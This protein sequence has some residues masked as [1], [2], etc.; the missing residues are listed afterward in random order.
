MS[1]CFK[2][3]QGLNER[4]IFVFTWV[5]NVNLININLLSF[6]ILNNDERFDL[7]KL[8]YGLEWNDIRL[9]IVKLKL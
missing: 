1:L 9:F 5:T 8:E 7:I 6:L 3:V 2:T 4:K